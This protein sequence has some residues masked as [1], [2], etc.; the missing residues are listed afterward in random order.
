MRSVII[1]DVRAQEHQR[2]RNHGL[3]FCLWKRLQNHVGSDDQVTHEF[4]AAFRH[5][6]A[7]AM[8]VVVTGKPNQVQLDM[9][10]ACRTALDRCKEM[11]R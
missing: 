4:A 10:N 6:H 1:K 7:A 3:R 2:S 11:L 9:F 8:S 5:Y